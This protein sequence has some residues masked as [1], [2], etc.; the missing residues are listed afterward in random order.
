MFVTESLGAGVDIMNIR[1]VIHVGEPY[2]IIN[3]D[4]EVGWGGRSGEIV[5]SLTLLSDEE[6]SRLCRRRA[7][8][9]SQDE[10]AI[11][12]FLTTKQCRRTAMSMYLNGEEY[13]VTC[14]SLK[15]EMCDNCKLDLS[16][17]V[18]GKRRVTDDEQ[19]ERRVRQRQSYE[20]RQ[21]DLQVAM[22]LES[23]RLEN[24]LLV[25]QNLQNECSVC[26][27]LE[28]LGQHDSKSCKYMEQALG[29]KYEAFKGN[30]LKYDRYSC[31]YRCSL[32]QGLCEDVEMGSC[33]R[34]DVILPLVIVGFVQQLK[35]EF[36]KLFE[37]ILDGQEFVNIFEYIE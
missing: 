34:R 33:F 14:E 27:L 9:L 25:V 23:S 16:Y 5:Q 30:Y 24:V 6:E 32:P 15:S 35:L 8:T 1:T 2:R 36:E 22:K 4:Q 19:L 20:R 12:E 26:W 18:I 3:F 13:R 10:R 31:C 37:E 28:E 21:S 7:P 11:H 17:T 29:M